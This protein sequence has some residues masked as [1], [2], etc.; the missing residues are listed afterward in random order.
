MHVQGM[1]VAEEFGS[2]TT[3]LVTDLETTME[4]N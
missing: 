1:F 3:P 4:G 2:A